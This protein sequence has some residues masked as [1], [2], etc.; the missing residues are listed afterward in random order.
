LT[1]ANQKTKKTKQKP[2]KKKNEQQQT[3]HGTWQC[4]GLIRVSSGQIKHEQTEGTQ[5][6]HKCTQLSWSV[7]YSSKNAK[8]LEK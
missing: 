2:K 3:G 4:G 1:N 7:M 6:T 8:F 5:S